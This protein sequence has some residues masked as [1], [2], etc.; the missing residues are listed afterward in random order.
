MLAPNCHCSHDQFPLIYPM[1]CV[2][3]V[4]LFSDMKSIVAEDA[5]A[6]TKL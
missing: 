1:Q 5:A 3:R 6:H 4:R 2:E